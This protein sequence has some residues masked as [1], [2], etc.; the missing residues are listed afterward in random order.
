M[1]QN[2][3]WSLFGLLIVVLI[4]QQQTTHFDQ[5][6]AIDQASRDQLGKMLNNFS[7]SLAGVAGTTG[8]P[9]TGTDLYD[10]SLYKV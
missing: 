2:S 4:I 7:T 5:V 1:N 9:F 3:M 10:P 6:R 8:L